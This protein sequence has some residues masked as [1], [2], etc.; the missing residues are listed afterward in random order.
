MS[1][2][3][4]TSAEFADSPLSPLRPRRKW[5]PEETSQLVDGCYTHGVGSWKKIL[6]DPQYNF[7]NRRAVDLKDRFRVLFPQEY[8]RLYG[9][10]DR[11]VGRVAEEYNLPSQ[12]PPFRRTPRRGKSHFT[13][14]EDAALIRGLTLHGRAWT[15]IAQ[16]VNIGLTHRRGSD[17]K[18]RCRNAFPEKYSRLGFRPKK[19]YQIEREKEIF[20]T[21]RISDDSP[22]LQNDS[23][24][25]QHDG[26]PPR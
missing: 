15:K 13:A 4:A 8:Q 3:R 16:D 11:G 19:M 1:A 5:T 12:P 14:E 17:L 25:L 26:V 24:Y 6:D 21:S 9:A 7:N 22:T 2:E 10:Q 20:N 18:D 23:L